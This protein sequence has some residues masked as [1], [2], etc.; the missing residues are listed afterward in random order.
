MGGT[1]RSYFKEFLPRKRETKIGPISLYTRNKVSIANF[2]E[3]VICD[4]CDKCNAMCSTLQHSQL[5]KICKNEKLDIL[6]ILLL[7]LMK[8]TISLFPTSY[9]AT[10]SYSRRSIEIYKLNNLLGNE[11]KLR[12]SIRSYS[13]LNFL[14]K[15]TLYS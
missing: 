9:R 11:Q 6:I 1:A 8:Y 7:P 13:S 12:R 14:Q 2:F 10:W 3:D 5:R 15:R 4:P